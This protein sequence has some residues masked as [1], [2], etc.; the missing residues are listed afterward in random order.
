V[1]SHDAKIVAANILDGN[2]HTP[3]YRGVPSVAFTLPPIAAVGLSEAAARQQHP[4]VRVNL[5]DV[6]DWYTAR[7]VGESVYAYK[8]L[9][10]EAG[11]QIL[12]AHLVGPHA[13]EVINLLSPCATILFEG[14]LLQHL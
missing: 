6:P 14:H 2:R 13:D 10:D 4:N 8:T 7:R 12:G 5:A 3:D 9:V 11:G 1:S